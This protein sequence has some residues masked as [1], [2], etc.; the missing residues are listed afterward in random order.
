MLH[1]TRLRAAVNSINLIP[2]EVVFAWSLNCPTVGPNITVIEDDFCVMGRTLIIN[3]LEFY[4]RGVSTNKADVIKFF[5]DADCGY[6]FFH[7]REPRDKE[8][9]S[10]TNHKSAPEFVLID[11]AAVIHIAVC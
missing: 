8:P 6:S 3:V 1:T 11:M 4:R 9:K 10:L 5:P 7:R 2:L